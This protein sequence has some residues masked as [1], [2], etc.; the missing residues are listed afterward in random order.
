MS[1]ILDALH[2]AREDRGDAHHLTSRVVDMPRQAPLLVKNTRSPWRS[3]FLLASL[4]S[5]LI[6]VVV[7]AAAAW[8]WFGDSGRRTRV[9]D[10]IA[11][12]FQGSAMAKSPAPAEPPAAATSLVQTAAMVPVDLPPPV[13]LNALP[14]Q[15]PAVVPTPPTA[16][17]PAAPQVAPGVPVQAAPPAVAPVQSAALTASAVG[18]P[19]ASGQVA[20]ASAPAW[21]LGTIMCDD[22]QDCAAVVNG[23]TVRVGDVVRE[24]KVMAVTATDVT[25]QHGGDAPLVLSLTN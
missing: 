21:R 24:H 17:V 13:A 1:V 11:S 6:M 4:G 9:G 2:K 14:V 3:L 12:T 16:S 8:W 7:L 20:A 18:T 25:L 19:A 5:L 15:A 10:L 22:G 23:R